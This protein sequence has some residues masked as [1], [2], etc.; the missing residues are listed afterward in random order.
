MSLA[1]SPLFYS[2]I[3]LSNTCP[4]LTQILLTKEKRK[5]IGKYIKGGGHIVS[6]KE[7]SRFEKNRRHRDSNSEDKHQKLVG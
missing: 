1:P 7:M 2:I 6:P 3:F 4:Y 5:L